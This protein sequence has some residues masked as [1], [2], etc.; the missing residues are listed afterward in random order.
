ML[1]YYDLR[2]FQLEIAYICCSSLYGAAISYSN[3]VLNFMS[4]PTIFKLR[5]PNVIWVFSVERYKLLF[6]YKKKII[7]IF[8]I[9]SFVK[10]VLYCLLLKMN[11]F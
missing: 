11:A 10:T 4:F 5:C 8:I 9:L 6:F 1:Y 2:I 7:L 3:Y